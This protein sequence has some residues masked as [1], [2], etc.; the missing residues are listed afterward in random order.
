MWIQ[1]PSIVL[2]V[3]PFSH[4]NS[5]ATVDKLLLD[6]FAVLPEGF[7]RFD[8]PLSRHAKLITAKS[9]VASNCG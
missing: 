9:I 7:L 3:L 2:P 6:N 5:P 4:R 8:R 1:D